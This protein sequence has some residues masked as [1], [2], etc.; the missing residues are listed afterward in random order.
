MGVFQTW[1]LVLGAAVITGIGGVVFSA[2]PARRRWGNVAEREPAG[3]GAYR[4]GDVTRERP[5]GT[6]PSVRL[7]SIG[8]V[9]WGFIT[10][11]VF[12]PAG[13]LLALASFDFSA[14]S[15]LGT[16]S[17]I[18]S[19]SGLALGLALVASAFRLVRRHP[20][21][22]DGARKIAR[23]CYVH[24]AAVW[25]GFS[26]AAIALEADSALGVVLALAVPCALGAVVAHQVQ[27]AADVLEAIDRLETQRLEAA[28]L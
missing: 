9:T 6:P 25:V 22:A 16:T 14:S 28:S 1:L 8:A 2:D 10:L 5:R 19:A 27:R 20:D 18:L 23:F 4:A 3:D 15:A 26:V 11:L 7:A 12:V 17:L 13:G 21:A 24:H